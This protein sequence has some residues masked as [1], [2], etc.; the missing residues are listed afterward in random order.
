LSGGDSSASIFIDAESVA[1]ISLPSPIEDDTDEF[2]VFT[3]AGTCAGRV[4]WDDDVNAV[5][6]TGWSDSVTGEGFSSGE[7][8]S[9][10]VWDASEDTEFTTEVTYQPCS[11]F[12]TTLCRDDGLWSDGAIYGLETITALSPI[13]VELASF[14]ARV[15]GSAVQLRWVT[16]SEDGNAGFHVQHRPAVSNAGWTEGAFVP[17]HGTRSTATTYRY[18]ISSLSPGR[19]LIRLRQVDLDGSVAF[20]EP[21]PATVALQEAA[22]V[23]PPSPNPFTERTAVSLMLREAQPVDVR[24]F[25]VLGREVQVLHRGRLSSGTRHVFSLR[26]ATLPA[27]TYFV[28]ITGST[29]QK[30]MP[31]V[32]VR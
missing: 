13:P 17:G 24:V 12:E 25:D 1:T 20:S 14:T 22:A 4:V 3:P 5:S 15:D 11:E 26:A 10:R 9:F 2:A 32:L 21:I 16:A 8:M 19:H 7:E 27:G 6:L 30:T 23:T 28:R 29:V 18:R 31:V